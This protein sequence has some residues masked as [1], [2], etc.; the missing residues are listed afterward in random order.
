MVSRRLGNR[1]L[2]K[3]ETRKPKSPDHDNR[4]TAPDHNNGVTAPHCDSVVTAPDHD[5]GVTVPHYDSGVT[6]YLSRQN[7]VTEN[8]LKESTTERRENEVHLFLGP[9]KGKMFH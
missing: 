2:W 3:R 9:S 8:S 1:T 4:V 5:N 7:R 6:G